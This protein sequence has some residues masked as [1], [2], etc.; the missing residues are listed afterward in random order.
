M[1]RSFPAL[2][3]TA[4]TL[5][6]A[7]S[8][9][10]DFGDPLF[11]GLA[12]RSI[13]PFRGGRVSAVAGV[14]GQP[15]VYYMGATGGG[16]WKTTNAGIEWT[17]I[18]DGQVKTGSVGAIAVAPS[19]PNVL[20][21]GMGE[22]CIRGNVSHGD[23]VYRSTD[24]GKTWTHVGLRDTM[25]IGRIRVH[26]LDPDLVY[27]AALG[28]TWGPHAER[29]VFRSKDGG[30]TW[31]K[32][33]FRGRS[34][35]RRRPR[36]RPDESARPLRGRSGRP[37]GRRGASR[38]AVPGAALH[39][40]TDGGDTWKKLDGKGL[41]KGALRPDRRERLPRPVGAR[42]RGDRGRGGRCLPLGRRGT[43]WERTNDD[44]K[45]RQRAWYYTHVDADPKERRHRLRPQ[46]GAVPVEGRRERRSRR[47]AC[48]TATTTTSG[49]TPEDPRRMIEGNDGGAA[50]RS[51]GA[52]PGRAS[53]TS[54][55]R[56][57]TT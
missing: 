13:G 22:S 46:R 19:D 18:T 7:T 54:R 39:K 6:A 21:V 1:T 25:Q 45:L 49:S 31:S 30:K 12:W 11:E 52:T 26:P 34:D 43:T 15:L 51:T 23:G 27:V 35:R 9:G 32:S 50:S 47:S 40:T 8:A 55:R 14:P 36:H 29:G 41:P 16:V 3:M 57:S 2:A 53:R 17:P 4:A 28:H 24:A 42:L 37:S 5:V 10:A 38:A 20:Y 33:L 48:R 56:S 44:R